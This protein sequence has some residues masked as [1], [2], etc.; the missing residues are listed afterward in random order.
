F[1][2]ETRLASNTWLAAISRS[3]RRIIQHLKALSTIISTA[4]DHLIVALTAPSESSNSLNL[5]EFVVPLSLEV[6]RI[7]RGF[8]RAS[9]FNFK[10]VKYKGKRPYRGCQVFATTVSVPVRPS[11]ARAALRG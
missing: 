10:K 3:G 7:I 9:T 6:G 1:L 8:E 11:A 5:K 4:F 2:R